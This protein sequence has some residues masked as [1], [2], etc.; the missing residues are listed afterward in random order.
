[1]IRKPELNL[2]GFKSDEIEIEEIVGELE[3]KGWIVSVS[4]YPKAIRIVVMPHIKEE[5]VQEFLKDLSSIYTKH[6]IDDMHQ[7]NERNAS[8][9]LADKTIQGK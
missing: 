2:V 1:L 5:H 8:I 3:A 6:I 4:A 9:K 7:D